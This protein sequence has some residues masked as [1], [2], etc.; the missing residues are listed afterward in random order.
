V[1]ITPEAYADFPDSLLSAEG[2]RKRLSN[3]G[4]RASSPR[5][6]LVTRLL[7]TSANDYTLP[8]EAHGW[9]GAAVAQLTGAKLKSVQIARRSNGMKAALLI[10]ASLIEPVAVVLLA[11][12]VLVILHRS[13]G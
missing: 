7:A 3:S 4:L 9:L 1:S 12:G 8:T 5:Q 2:A 6:A 11:V 10:A 13:H